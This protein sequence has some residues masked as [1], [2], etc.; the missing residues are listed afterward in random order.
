ME[1]VTIEEIIMNFDKEDIEYLKQQVKELNGTHIVLAENKNMSSS[2]FGQ[3]SAII[4]GGKAS[5]KINDCNG[6]WLNDLPSQRQYFTKYAIVQGWI[7]DRNQEKFNEEQTALIDQ[8]LSDKN[9]T[10]VEFLERQ[11]EIERKYNI[12]EYGV[13]I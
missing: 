12:F 3:K 9:I 2:R 13:K 10:E 8:F 7:D 5:Y 4:V 1:E 11:K 6:K